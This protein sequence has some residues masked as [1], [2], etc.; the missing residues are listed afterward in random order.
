MTSKDTLSS[1]VTEDAALSSENKDKFL[2][3]R[4]FFPLFIYIFFL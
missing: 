3:E 2:F 1:L 4:D